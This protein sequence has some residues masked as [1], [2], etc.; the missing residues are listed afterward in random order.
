VTFTVAFPLIAQFV[1]PLALVGWVAFGR[2]PY[3][4]RWWLLIAMAWMWI[5]AIGIAGLWLV[6]PWYLYLIYAALLAA[7]IVATW[8]QKVALP[9]LPQSAAARIGAAMLVVLLLSA[10]GLVAWALDGRRAPDA[11]AEAAFPLRAGTY[12]VVNGGRNALVNAHVKTLGDEPRFRPWRG[13]SHGVDIVKL[14]AAGFRA[15]GILARDPRRYEIFGDP[16]HAPCTG[17]VV[18]AVDGIVDQRVPEMNRAAMA[19]N[20]VIL[21]CNGIW[22]VVGHLRQGSVRVHRGD[23]IE[24]GMVVGEVGNSGNSSE[25]HL[26][27][28]AQKPGTAA[29]PLSGEPVPLRFDARYLARNHRIQRRDGTVP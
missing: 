1:L 13:Q 12:L 20:H 27:I 18:A 29:E 6:L 25:P 23:S 28:H 14:N 26:H 21:D 24:S 8:R 22:L 4:A 9:F 3:R 7:A 15:R 16:V 5:A 10:G 19:G 11:G 2:H 17:S